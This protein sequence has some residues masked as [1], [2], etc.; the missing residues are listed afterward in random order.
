MSMSQYDIDA[1][2]AEDNALITD[3]TTQTAAIAAAQTAFAAEIAAL[4]AQGVDTSGLDAANAQL[5][6]A[7]APLDAAVS[8]LTA[9]SAPPATPPAS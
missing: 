7:Q 6:A 8:A 3:L 5:T 2:V 1:A 4:Q 9:A